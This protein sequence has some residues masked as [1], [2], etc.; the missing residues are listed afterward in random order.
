MNIEI[1]YFDILGLFLMNKIY[2]TCSFNSLSTNKSEHCN[3]N[4]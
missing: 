4:K 1:R 3:G 2:L